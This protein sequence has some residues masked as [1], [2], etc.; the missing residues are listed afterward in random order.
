MHNVWK[1]KSLG[2]LLL[3]QNY[4]VCL[5]LQ[6]P[7]MQVAICCDSLYKK[8]PLFDPVHFGWEAD[9]VN[10]CFTSCNM[11]WGQAC[12]ITHV[13]KL[14][15]CGCDLEKGMQRRQ[16]WLHA[17]TAAMHHL[18][19]ML[20]FLYYVPQPFQQRQYRSWY[21]SGR[22]LDIYNLPKLYSWLFWIWLWKQYLILW[23]DFC[24]FKYYV[25]ESDFFY[26]LMCC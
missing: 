22:P 15:H 16:Q 8:S 7:F 3:H 10:K 20:C 11:C 5:P 26:F 9:T 17:L 21:S 12:A 24:T 13:L 6:K 14:V 23:F 4:A 19:V 2:D 25:W 1:L 18:L